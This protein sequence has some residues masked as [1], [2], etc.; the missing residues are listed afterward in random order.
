MYRGRKDCPPALIA[1]LSLAIFF[2]ST[3]LQY[4]S[5]QIGIEI[6][7]NAGIKPDGETEKEE[8]KDDDMY[9]HAGLQTDPEI[10]TF[11]Q[12]AQDYSESEQYD[13]AVRLLQKVLEEGDQAMVKTGRRVYQPASETAQ[14]MLIEL[15]EEGLETYRILADANAAALLDAPGARRDSDALHQIVRQY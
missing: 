8:R 2:L 10:Q 14:D 12:R 1:I 7:G 9:Q 11:L 4:V 15:P 6:R 13:T 3:P 5:A